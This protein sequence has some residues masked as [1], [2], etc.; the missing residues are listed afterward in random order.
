MKETIVRIQR[1]KYG[2]HFQ[3]TRSWISAASALAVVDPDKASNFIYA[4]IQEL[5]TLR[6]EL[7]ASVSGDGAS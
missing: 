1:G 6:T 3:V 4:A 2:P 7:V 5:K